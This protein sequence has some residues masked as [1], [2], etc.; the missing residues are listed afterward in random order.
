MFD[1]VPY[2]NQIPTIVKHFHQMMKTKTNRNP[3]MYFSRHLIKLWREV[4]WPLGGGGKIKGR[5]I[6]HET[7]QK[8]HDNKI[9]N[10]ISL[11]EQTVLIGMVAEF[12][13]I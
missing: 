13:G 9:Q 4:L 6:L 5:L 3:K 1:F 2:E 7:K 10:K 8:N 12:S 11:K